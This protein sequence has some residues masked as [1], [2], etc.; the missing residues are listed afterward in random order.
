MKDLSFC[1]LINVEGNE[2]ENKA[3]MRLLCLP[4]KNTLEYLKKEP[5]DFG[6]RL[7]TLANQ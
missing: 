4:E 3:D 6:S 7:Y 2:S 5:Q 1:E